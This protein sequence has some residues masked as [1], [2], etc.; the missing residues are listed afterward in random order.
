MFLLVLDAVS[1]LTDSITVTVCDDSIVTSSSLPSALWDP[2]LDP[3][4]LASCKR[5]CLC[6]R[7]DCVEKDNGD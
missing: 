4:Q 6:R 3:K 2:T 7:E 1:L 5:I